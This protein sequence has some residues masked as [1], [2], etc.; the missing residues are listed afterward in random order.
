MVG[1]YEAAIIERDPAGSGLY[2]SR[3]YI[4]PPGEEPE[5][6]WIRRDYLPL[7]Q[8][9][10]LVHE[11]TGGLYIKSLGSK[12]AKWRKEPVSDKQLA[13]LQRIH[14]RLARQALEAGW[15]KQMASEAITYYRL[16][17]TLLH[18]PE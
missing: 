9:V 17:Q 5:H 14:P 2:R 3:L 10:A 6:Q 4:M 7:R 18:P 1:R 16:R 15:T 13:T 12:D 8:Q 11:A